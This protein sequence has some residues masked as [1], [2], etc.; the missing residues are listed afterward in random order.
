MEIILYIIFS[1]LGEI[2]RKYCL[3]FVFIFKMISDDCIVEQNE[4]TRDR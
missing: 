4:T 3:L 1:L 2:L